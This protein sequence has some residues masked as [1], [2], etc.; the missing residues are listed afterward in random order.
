M[1]LTD[2][3]LESLE[4]LGRAMDEVQPASRGHF[5]EFTTRAAAEFRELR[6]IAEAMNGVIRDFPAAVFCHCALCQATRSYFTP[7][8]PKEQPK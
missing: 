8:A 1:R 7:P 2:Q 3:E 6:A 4:Q 5:A